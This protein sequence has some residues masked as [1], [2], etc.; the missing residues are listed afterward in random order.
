MSTGE[1]EIASEPVATPRIGR[2]AIVFEFSYSNFGQQYLESPIDD[3]IGKIT[4]VLF[5]Q[6]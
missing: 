4:P 1:E 5:N 2:V 3:S 6:I